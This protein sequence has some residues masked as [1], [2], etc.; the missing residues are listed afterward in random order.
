MR[1]A[2][3]EQQDVFA[4]M[5]GVV[6][7]AILIGTDLDARI[8]L[9]NRGAERYYGH[10]SDEAVGRPVTLVV[11]PD[12]REAALDAVRAPVLA[13]ETRRIDT[14]HLHRDGTAL[15]VQLTMSPLRDGSGAV[16]GIASV[17]HDLAE[18]VERD[19]PLRVMVERLPVP[20]LHREDDAFYFN[21]AAARLIGY[22]R[23]EVP[24][25]EAWF[26]RLY[27][28]EASA[29]RD[30]YELDRRLGHTGARSVLV[31]RKDGAKR[32]VELTGYLADRAEVWLIR[33]VTERRDLER[34][35]IEVSEREQR[36]IGRDLHDGLGAHLTAVAMLCRTLVRRMEKGVP[37]PAA[38][39][40]EVADLVQEGIATAR[41]HARG[42]NPVSIESA[43]LAGALQEL[44]N[45]LELRTGVRCRLVLDRPV[46][47]FPSE[48][49]T[50]LFRIAQEAAS[51]ALKHSGTDEIVF[52][53]LRTDGGVTL[54]VS[55]RGC[56]LPDTAQASDGLGLHA[57]RYRAGFVGATLSLDR[58]A[59]GG[60]AVSCT[61]AP[62]PAP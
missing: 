61:L 34:A 51:N 28:A 39:L 60:T 19:L 17:A 62:P 41:A 13:G 59:D 26:D 50:H 16:V 47:A 46:A 40:A 31:T 20:A 6:P 44:A 7:E 29:M 24:T 8:T 55:D 35:L 18:A 37:V 10:T 15:D 56:G 52:A 11:P 5:A 9:W 48:V 30:L 2:L 3:P 33:D 45:G 58:P 22:T 12:R 54:R 57:M 53:L 4:A 42:L 36:R 25:I 1:R 38:A 21:D 14:V 49:A 32:F 27:G 23:R 43:G